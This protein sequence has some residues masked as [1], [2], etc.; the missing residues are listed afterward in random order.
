MGLSTNGSIVLIPTNMD[1]TPAK[2]P[3]TALRRFQPKAI[4]RSKRSVEQGTKQLRGIPGYGR[5][6]SGIPTDPTTW[7]RPVKRVPNTSLKATVEL[8]MTNGAGHSM[9]R[10]ALRAADGHEVPVDRKWRN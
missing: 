4:L 2:P 10:R 6:I 9:K 7:L 8:G 5:Y 3:I 1:N